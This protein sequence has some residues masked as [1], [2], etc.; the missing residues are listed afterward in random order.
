MRSK[1]DIDWR[2]LL[3]SA[4]VVAVMLL[5]VYRYP[6]YIVPYG[7]I[8]LALGILGSLVWAYVDRRRNQ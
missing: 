3:A 7:V 5:F 2:G 8:L 1:L 6:R 4:L